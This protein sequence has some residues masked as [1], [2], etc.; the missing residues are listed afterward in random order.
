MDPNLQ[1]AATVS[2]LGLDKQ[3]ASGMNNGSGS[4]TASDSKG[5]KKVGPIIAALVI[6]LVLII[7]ALYIFASSLNQQ[8]VPT[9]DVT[10][11]ASVQ[12]ITNNSTDVQ[13]LQNDLDNSTTGLDNQNF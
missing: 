4:P 1:T 9:D 2:S 11:A 10:A 5:H 12:P 7:A 13:S 3:S 6:T 8:A